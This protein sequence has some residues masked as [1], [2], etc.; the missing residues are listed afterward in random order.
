M[1]GRVVDLMGRVVQRIV[2]MLGRAAK[3]TCAHDGPSCRH[4]GRELASRSTPSLWGDAAG[5][6]TLC[7]T[8][9]PTAS[10]LPEP[11]PPPTKLKW[12]VSCVSP[13]TVYC[14]SPPTNLA[15]ASTVVP[16]WMSR[17]PNLLHECIISPC[18]TKPS[19]STQEPRFI[20][21]ASSHIHMR[22]M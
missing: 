2:K 12:P 6:A 15:V 5:E 8:A 14:L 4:D 20:A 13:S 1:G 22:G 9:P 11:A 17:S 10:L 3:T 16:G 7:H 18:A 19:P 21:K